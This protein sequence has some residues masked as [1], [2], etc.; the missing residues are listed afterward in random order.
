[1]PTLVPATMR[2]EISK[3]KI[4]KSSVITVSRQNGPMIPGGAS[5]LA[6]LCT[7]SPM[8]INSGSN[9]SRS[10][11]GKLPTTVYVGLMSIRLFACGNFADR[12][13]SRFV[14]PIHTLAVPRRHLGLS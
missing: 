11:I 9:D 10:T 1:M 7:L 13:H 3:V 4:F 2:A 8:R 14:T 5:S 6:F 12:V